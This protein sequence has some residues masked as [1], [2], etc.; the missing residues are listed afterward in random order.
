MRANSLRARL[1]LNFWGAHAPRVLAIAP[2]RSRVVRVD[3]V[4]PYLDP[5]LARR[6]NVHARRAPY[7][8][9]D[10]ESKCHYIPVSDFVIFAFDPE[11]AGFAG[12][13]ER[14][15]CDQI[16]VVNGFGR[17][18]AAFKVGMDGTRCGRRFCTS[19]NRPGT[20]LFFSG[21]EESSQAQQVISW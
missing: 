9:S 13:R 3:R 5:V 10:V 21:G 8:E 14:P 7:P 4:C 17:D 2:S 19:V 16:V 6:R 20:G 11:F 1:R 15:K 12:F 18:K